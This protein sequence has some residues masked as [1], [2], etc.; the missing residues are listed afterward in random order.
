M[1]SYGVNDV[2]NIPIDVVGESDDVILRPRRSPINHVDVKS[3]SNE[4]F[5]E[6]SSRSEIE[7][8]VFIDK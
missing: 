7:N 4:I 8:V 3:L 2:W 1:P 5:D 6:T